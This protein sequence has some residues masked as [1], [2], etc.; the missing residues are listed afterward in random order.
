MFCIPIIARNTDEALLKIGRAEPLADILEI[1]LDMMDAFDLSGIIQ[2][3][4][5]PI[6]V[7]YR[8]EKE[9]GR[10]TADDVTRAHYLSKAIEAGA[11]F[12]DVEYG[13]PAA[14][15]NRIFRNRGRPKI[16][17][18]LHDIHGTPSRGKLE[19]IFLRM[20]ATG[21]DSVKIVTQAKAPEDNLR[22]LEL[23]PLAQRQGVNITAF[24]MGHIGRISRVLSHLMGGYLTFGSLDAGEESADGQI[25]I[26]SMKKILAC[27]PP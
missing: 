12:V 5:K 9:G 22:V 3:T 18:S 4:E 16:I 8:S 6:L 7:T 17:V 19:T 11:D 25:P 23:I 15:R 1:R 14:F 2:S 10:G 20:A 24:C 27:F 21:S 26:T 13:M